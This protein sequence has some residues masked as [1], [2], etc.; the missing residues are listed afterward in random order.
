M[1]HRKS[2]SAL[3]LKKAGH[4]LKHHGHGVH[5]GHGRHGRDHE[6][7]FKAKGHKKKYGHLARHL[8]RGELDR[9]NHKVL[10]FHG[11]EHSPPNGTGELG[12]RGRS[13]AKADVNLEKCVLCGKCQRVCPTEA[14]IVNEDC[15]HIDATRC[16]GCGHCVERC[17]TGALFLVQGEPSLPASQMGYT[18]V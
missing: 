7:L 17:K 5:G 16:T 14:I 6:G 15:I 11:R 18:P 4:G 8:E 2:G 13:D 9:G 1:H 10:N 3:G 12:S